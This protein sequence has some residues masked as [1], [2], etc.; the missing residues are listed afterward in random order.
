[1]APA[2]SFQ[3]Y[4]QFLAGARL[5]VL[6]R[7]LGMALAATG[8]MLLL[9]YP[10][11]LALALRFR[12]RTTQLL[13]FLF[14]V[15]FLVNYVVRTFAWS[16]V[17]AR[18]GW[19]NRALQSL[20]LAAQPLDW[21]LYSDVSVY[22][23]IVTA[24]MPFMI[25]PIWLSLAGIDRRLVEASWVLGAAPVETFWRVVLPLSLP[26]V[27]AAAIFGFV[28][29]FGEVAVPAILGGVGYQLFGNAIMSSLNV[30]NYPLAAAMSTV[31]V[32]LMLLLL[33]AWYRFFD[34]RLLLGKIMGRR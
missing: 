27:F 7:S 4:A 34:V 22:L 15:P 13:L 25:L 28:G 12:P 26:G 31:A 33:L 1:M 32:G 14:S 6:T 29:A 17:L 9:A 5:G 21:L 18:E 30:L 10:I 11:A 20:G 8:L 3:A 2:L 23:G 16:D 24:Y 19:V